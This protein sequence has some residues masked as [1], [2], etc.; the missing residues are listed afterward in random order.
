MPSPVQRTPKHQTNGR[1][2]SSGGKNKLKR[3][4]R[5]YKVGTDD[6]D[7]GSD[8]KFEEVEGATMESVAKLVAGVRY[9]LRN[10][11]PFGMVTGIVAEPGIGKSAFILWLAFIVMTGRKWFNGKKGPEPGKVLWCPTE[12][13]MA[14][15]LQ[16]M[17]DWKIPLK[18]MILPFKD[19]PLR[20]VNLTDPKHLEQIEA[21]INKHKPLMV[22]LDS[23]RSGHDGDENSSRVGKVLQELATIAER[24]GTAMIVVH[25]TRK[26]NEDEEISANSSR[27]SNAILAMMRSQI[28]LDKP[29]PDSKQV[30][31]RVL[32]ENL[33]IAPK[34]IGFEVT[35]KGLVFGDAPTK[36]KKSNKQD[37]AAEWLLAS[38]EPKKIYLA[39]DLEAQAEQDGHAVRTLRRA[40]AKLGIK[41]EE[42]KKDG[43]I[44]HWEW[45]LPE[46]VL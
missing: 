45:T 30:R 20:P 12:N 25:H 37:E 36:P 27:G 9:L 31:V 11:I 17:R 28:G 23:L 29:D 18:K 26:L 2:P 13:D 1:S 8:K 42:K 35:K 38:M 10:W 6:I 24:T 21:L 14:I 41:K 4:L 33:G 3:A 15:T 7:I 22:V 44:D 32:K 16:R 40:A 19:D 46:G 34:A 43:K 39:S 5:S